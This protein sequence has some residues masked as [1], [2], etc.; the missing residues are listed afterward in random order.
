MQ[1]TSSIQTDSSA[2]NATR[3]FLSGAASSAAG[4]VTAASSAASGLL[5]NVTNAVSNTANTSA[6]TGAASAASDLLSNATSAISSTANSSAVAGAVTATSSLLNN[7]TTALTTPVNASA[8][9]GTGT[10]AGGAETDSLLPPDMLNSTVLNS[11]IADGVIHSSLQKVEGVL[12]GVRS[13]LNSSSAE[14]DAGM[15]LISPRMLASS[16]PCPDCLLC[17][18][19]AQ[20]RCVCTDVCAHDKTIV[21]SQLAA[22]AH[23]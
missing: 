3:D 2:V 21:V 15:L 9:N 23:G 16:L 14:E 5:S 19:K 18:T 12:S 11:S 7:A 6:M 10:A 1:D 8:L 22:A 13:G 17:V 20:H 4:A